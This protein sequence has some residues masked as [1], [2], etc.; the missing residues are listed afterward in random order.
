MAKMSRS[1]SAQITFILL[2]AVTLSAKQQHLIYESDP[3]SYELWFDD[4]RISL[5]TM[6]E[7][8]W[9]SPHMPSP[10]S[11]PSPFIQASSSQQT[12]TGKKVD[13][14]ILVPALEDCNPVGSH[15]ED[16]SVPDQA[17]LQNA[18]INLRRGERQL[19]MLRSERLP[20]TLQ[21][22]QAYL[23]GYMQFFL[24]LQKARYEY[25]KTGNPLQ[26]Q[27]I[28]GKECSSS[29]ANKTNQ[30]LN[31]ALS[32]SSTKQQ[33]LQLTLDW[34][35]AVLRCHRNNNP[36]YPVEAWNR[37]LSEFGITERVYYRHIE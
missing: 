14:V 15:C 27:E 24:D 17:F 22:V 31:R 23:I 11:V 2:C 4:Q 29:N 37:F 28:L 1:I 19:Q 13:K 8:A 34:H 7:I 36:K 12:A 33:K 5:A 6:R 3:E 20:A 35:T 10:T 18:T 25:L 9:L 32:L 21:P 30:A 26:L 16:K